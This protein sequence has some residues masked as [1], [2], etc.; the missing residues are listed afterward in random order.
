MCLAVIHGVKGVG[1]SLTAVMHIIIAT[2]TVELYLSTP[3]NAFYALINYQMHLI[4]I[5]GE[6]VFYIEIKRT[7]TNLEKLL[8]C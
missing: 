4:F 7:Q 6:G 3:T 1:E 5:Y 8:C 2:K